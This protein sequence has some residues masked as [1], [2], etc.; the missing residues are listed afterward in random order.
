MFSI[1]SLSFNKSLLER[2]YDMYAGDF[3][4]K[5]LLCENYR[6][7]EAIIRYT[8]DLFYEQKLLASGHQKPHRSWF[9]LTVFTARGEDVQDAN[10]TSFYNHYEVYEIVD[11]VD[12][13]LSLIHI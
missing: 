2:L 11:R 4:C 13:L 8:S 7:H 9:P 1:L 12:E 10:S 6:S 3:A 5:I